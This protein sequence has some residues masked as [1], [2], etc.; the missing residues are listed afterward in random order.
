MQIFLDSFWELFWFFVLFNLILA[1]LVFYDQRINGRSGFGWAAFIVLTGVI[2]LFIYWLVNQDVERHLARVQKKKS[3]GERAVS[4]KN[5]H[6]S[7]V[8]GKH[9]GDL[10]KPPVPGEPANEFDD[11]ELQELLEFKHFELAK[12]HVS[13]LIKLAEERDDDSA[14]DK[15]EEYLDRII[16]LERESMKWDEGS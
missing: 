4:I 7:S 8:D 6:E 13:R 1:A 11:P 16:E 12:E 15:F 14:R 9:W 2:G 5:P 10:A 3:A